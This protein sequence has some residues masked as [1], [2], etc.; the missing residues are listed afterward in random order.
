MRSKLIGFAK[1]A[2][3]LG[4]RLY[5]GGEPLPAF[6]ITNH[7]PV[8][9]AF[10][11]DY[12]RNARDMQRAL[13]AF[14]RP[15]FLFSLGYHCE[16]QERLQEIISQAAQVQDV[17]DVHETH[18]LC[19]S[20]KEVELL[21]GAGFSAILANANA[22]L[23]E[24]RYPL[25]NRPK[26]Y[27]AIYIAR[28]TPC[29]RHPLAK[30][31]PKLRLIGSHLPSERQ[32]FLEFRAALSHANWTESVLAKDVPS[33]IA[34]AHVGL[35]LS[36]VEGA[37]YVSCE[38]LLCGRPVV[39]TPNIGGRD[40]FFDPRW[41]IEAQPNEDDIFRAVEELKARKIP[42]ELIRQ[43]TIAKLHAARQPVIELIQRIFDERW[44]P[45]D[46]SREWGAAFTHKLG[47]RCRVS[48]RNG[49]RVL[50]AG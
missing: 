34:S 43:E 37:M 28:F 48:F 8:Y 36:D 9:A 2:V 17:L 3:H 12:F 44:I 38:Y 46:F 26:V 22:F 27:D 40:V 18:F 23:D 32:V 47:L 16:T 4:E 29:K 30:K 24:N 35:C 1:Q 33:E 31:I 25:V 13:A 10:W 15:V 42:P 20:E 6:C 11:F 49:K 50:R 41:V 39:S 14:E 45:V 7:G 21:T 5:F 19:N